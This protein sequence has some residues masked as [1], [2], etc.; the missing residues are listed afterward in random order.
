MS[1]LKQDGIADITGIVMNV[2]CGHQSH[3]EQENLTQ[4]LI[5]ELGKEYGKGNRDPAQ[6][7]SIA[8]KYVLEIR[9]YEPQIEEEVYRADLESCP[10]TILTLD[11]PSLQYLLPYIHEQSSVDAI[12]WGDRRSPHQERQVEKMPG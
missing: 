1:N 12:T 10:E 3:Q 7:V 4:A 5:V 8:T 9:S 2:L 11:T 6:L